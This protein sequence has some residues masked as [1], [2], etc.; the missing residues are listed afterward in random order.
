MHRQGQGLEGWMSFLQEGDW[1]PLLLQD[2]RLSTQSRGKIANNY[3]WDLLIAYRPITIKNYQSAWLKSLSLHCQTSKPPMPDVIQKKT[4]ILIR[5]TTSQHQKISSG[6]IWLY[7]FFRLEDARSKKEGPVLCWINQPTAPTSRK[8]AAAPSRT[9][10]L[11][12]VAHSSRRRLAV[13]ST[14]IRMAAR[15]RLE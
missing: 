5:H 14:S 4:H 3:L 8:E 1:M 12:P 9:R 7:F 10:P 6:F 15:W 13:H 11:L 2:R